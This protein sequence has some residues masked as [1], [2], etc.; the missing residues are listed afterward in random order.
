MRSLPKC[1]GCSEGELIDGCP[2]CCPK[3]TPKLD[4][5]KP[6]VAFEEGL[7]AKFLGSLNSHFGPASAVRVTMVSGREYIMEIRADGTDQHNRPVIRN[8]THATTAARVDWHRPIE[9]VGSGN[10]VYSARHL[11]VFGGDSYRR[12]RLVAIDWTTHES[13]DE[14]TEDG[15]IKRFGKNVIRNVTG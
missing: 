3:K 1:L 12:T 6:I 2:E 15:T 14:V 11:G 10:C 4:W 8:K 7:K 13:Y 9:Y 5:S